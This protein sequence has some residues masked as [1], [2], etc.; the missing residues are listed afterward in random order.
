MQIIFEDYYLLVVNKPAGLSSENGRSR[1][2]SAERDALMYFSSALMKN[3]SSRRIKATPFL[4]AAHR[5]DRV[6]SGILVFA[7]TKTA[8]AHLMGQFEA[9]NVE[10]TYWAV[11]EKMPPAESGTLSHWL[12]RSEDGKSAIAL[13]QPARDGQPSTLDYKCLEIKG[14]G[15]L[16]EIR[17]HEGRF[18]Q[19]RAQLAQVGCPIVGDVAYGAKPWR[20][21]EIKL[22]ARRL[23]LHHPKTDAPLELDVL[24]GE[25]W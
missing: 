11:V 2:P 18:H 19:I 3:S 23:V 20:E 15:A 16:L 17:P 6:A 24:P 14:K 13:E 8:L 1:H 4:R 22:H 12:K 7:K 9:R 25:D 10:K 21:Y 5:L